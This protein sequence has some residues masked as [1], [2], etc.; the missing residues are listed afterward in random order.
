MSHQQ[1]SNTVVAIAG[2]FGAVYLA[3]LPMSGTIALR[4]VTLVGLLLVL[5]WCL[6]TSRL[7]LRPGWLFLLWAAY[8]LLFPVISS[9][10]AVAWQN[11]GG[12]WARSLLAISAGAGLAFL[13]NRSSWGTVLH[14]GIVSAVPLLVHLALVIWKIYETGGIPWGY[15]G[16]EKHHA[17]L[18]YAAG[19]ATIL[20]A[21][22]AVSG[23]GRWRPAIITLIICALLST[24]VAYSRAG[25]VFAIFGGV[26]VCLLALLKV[27]GHQRRRILGITLTLLVVALILGFLALKKDSRWQTT[28]DKLRWGLL[29]GQALEVACHG[30]AS[31]ESVV[32]EQLGS[33]A[34]ANQ[35]I[36]SVVRDGDGARVVALRVGLQ[37][38]LHHPWGSDGSREAFRKLL[39]G[40]CPDPVLQIAHAHN[41][42][43]DTLLAIGWGG[44][45]LYLLL[46]LAFLR[47]G[48]VGI[49]E[50]SSVQLPWALVLSAL[51]LF[52]ILRGLADSVYRDHMLEMQGFMLAYA[53][54]NLRI[55]SRSD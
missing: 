41:G 55:F 50:N 49:R 13:L 48:L 53:W 5:T 23:A 20:L 51:A 22:A 37:L 24:V 29:A 39:L 31:I 46:M 40:Y 43:V 34:Y 7:S 32:I 19:Q 28:T 6:Y 38:S 12:Q 33:G 30:Q 45:L 17:D 10:P 26:L 27:S 18:G 3:V 42:W 8:L 1:P 52:W 54:A 4:N 25:L 44:A 9:D 21:V 2:T 35:I 47:C 15:W 11:L 36:D 16:R 14:L